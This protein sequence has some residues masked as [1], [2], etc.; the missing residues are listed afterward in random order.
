MIPHMV[1][2]RFLCTFMLLSLAALTLVMFI[3]WDAI[4]SE[5]DYVLWCVHTCPL[6]IDFEGRKNSLRQLVDPNS[7]LWAPP[8]HNAREIG[9][10]KTIVSVCD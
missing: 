9:K 2:C 10:S 7:T 3:I 4:C 5:I 6:K 8:F 1:T